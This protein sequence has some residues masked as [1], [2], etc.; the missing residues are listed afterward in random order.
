LSQLFFRRSRTTSLR[1]AKAIV[2]AKGNAA[3]LAHVERLIEE[4]RGSGFIAAAIA[5]GRRR[6]GASPSARAMRAA[7][8][9]R[10]A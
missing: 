10:S 6:R 1:P 8:S 4:P 2:V 3:L 9:F 5:R 7:Q